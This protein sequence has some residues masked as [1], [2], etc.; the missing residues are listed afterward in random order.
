MPI[1]PSGDVSNGA[2]TEQ[3]PS[4]TVPAE[5]AA[6]LAGIR[7]ELARI[8]ADAGLAN[9]H[10]LQWRDLDDVE[11]GGS[12]VHSATIARIWADAGINVVMRSSY[13]QGH[14]P[15]EE[16]DGVT[17]IRR[18]GRY[19]VFPRAAISEAIGR[20]GKRDGLVEVWNG[21][22]FLSPL[23]CRGPRIVFLHHLHADMWRMALPENPKLAQSGA[24]F[25][26]SVAPN[27]YK[28]S[29]IVTLSSS[30]RAELIEQMGFSP[31]QVTVAPPGIDPRFVPG[32]SKSPTPL[33]L[34]V[35]RLMP[36]KHFDD[37]L[38]IAAELRK[39]VPDLELVI[40]GSGLE[41]RHL[42]DLRE[43]L[44]ATDW[45]TLAGRVDDERLLMLYQRAWAVVSA[46]SREGW[47]MTMTEAAACGTP[48]VA[49]DIPGHRDAVADGQSGLLASTHEALRGHLHTVL[50]DAELRTRLSE[51][52]RRHA[53]R[54]SWEATARTTLSVLA[55]V[56]RS[57]S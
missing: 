9:I 6:D 22:P 54:F 38:R 1:S 11:A 52:A 23:W 30:S 29:R 35:G 50:T 45:V 3:L 34:S 48:A 19:L 43:E 32:E 13:A 8:A 24:F 20:H 39:D 55:E 2:D 14:P 51:G 12:E 36:S 4:G 25:E 53:S 15:T 40:V 28:G 42:E 33:L 17:V 7:N 37:L 16:R 31:S 57:K 26:R 27:F 41:R 49:T 18:A 46:S 44:D 47:G 10:F 56:A 5:P 21:V